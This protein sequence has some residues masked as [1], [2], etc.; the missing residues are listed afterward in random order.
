MTGGTTS[1]IRL[2]ELVLMASGTPSSDV[3]AEAQL[4]RSTTAG[5]GTAVTPSPVD[6]A[7]PASIVAALENLTAEPTYSAGHV[8]RRVFNPRAVHTW[9]AYDQKSEIVS[10]ATANNGLGVQMISAGG[11]GTAM[12]VEAGFDQ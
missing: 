12:L 1:R 4:R 5:T 2:Q 10:P 7:D 9:V 6:S 11:I 3:G 8:M